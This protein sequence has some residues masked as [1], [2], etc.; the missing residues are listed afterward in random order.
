MKLVGGIVALCLLSV[1]ANAALLSRRSGQAYYDTVLDITW[2]ADG[3]LAATRPFGL[4]GLGTSTSGYGAMD[5]NTSQAWIAAMNAAGYL[6]VRDW[7]QSTVVDTDGPDPDSLGGDGCNLA[8]AGTDCGWN[9][10]PATGEIAHL[11]YVT[12]G[13]VGG[14][15]PDGVHQDWC[16]TGMPAPPAC[17]T[18]LGPFTN[19]FPNH[20]WTRTEFAPDTTKVWEFNARIGSQNINVKT[21][22]SYVWAVRDGDIGLV[23]PT[24]V[25]DGPLAVN[26]GV[27]AIIPVG[28]NDIGFTDPVSVTVITPPGK[29]TIG[30]ISPPGPTTGMTI[31]YT[32]NIG[33]SGADTFV[34]VMTDSTP[35]SDLA[36]V[37]VDTNPDSDSDSV[38]DRSD[39]C[40]VVA[41]AAQ[42]DSDGDG[43]GNRCDGD[44]NNNDFTNSQ[45]YVLFRQQL[46]QPSV[47]PLFNKA[48]ITCNGVVNAQDYVLFRSLL[49]APPGPSGLVP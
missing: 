29:G 41:N 40:R 22:I 10:D 32:A 35:A 42:C 3:N 6:G 15:D 5:W 12:L 11:Y 39:N 23:V 31:S 43:F 44:L 25:D 49:G 19:F 2:V 30:A 4:S 21:R 8:Y 33:A 46:G 17:L 48:D 1:S 36:T 9:V 24:A 28:A 13:N 16:D 18:N 37:T 26:E 47:G 7:R 20:Y 14:Y 38:P 45:D 34:Y 27:A